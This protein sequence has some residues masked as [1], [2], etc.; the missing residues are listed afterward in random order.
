MSN[1]SVVF[2]K[3]SSSK[4]NSTSLPKRFTEVSLPKR[5]SNFDRISSTAPKEP[6]NNIIPNIHGGASSHGYGAGGS[7]VGTHKYN[8]DVTVFGGVAG[9]MAHSNHTGKNYGNVSG[10]VI[11][12]NFKC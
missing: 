2:N 8:D 7:I 1:N 10:G 9:G 5:D 6:T 3:S 11:G 12:A 4:N